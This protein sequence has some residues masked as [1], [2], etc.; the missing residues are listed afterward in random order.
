MIDGNIKCLKYDYKCKVNIPIVFN[1]VFLDKN[2]ICLEIV[3]D[4]IKEK[5][6]Q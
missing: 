6:N 5:Y 3:L 1:M 2:L 4:K